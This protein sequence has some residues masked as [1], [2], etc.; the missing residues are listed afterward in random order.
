MN[1]CEKEIVIIFTLGVDIYFHR[2][3]NAVVGLISNTERPPD[4]TAGAETRRALN[5]SS[6]GQNIGLPLWVEA[7]SYTHLTLP[8]ITE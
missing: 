7:V 5:G 2:P 1:E 3:H 6:A 4:D 8:T